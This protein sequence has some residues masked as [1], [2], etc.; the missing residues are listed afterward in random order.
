MPPSI[1][2]WNKFVQYSPQRRWLIAEAALR[3]LIARLLLSCLPFRRLAAMFSRTVIE[4]PLQKNER[5]RLQEEVVWAIEKAAAHLPGK[6]VCFPRAIAAQSMLYRRGISTTM[7][8]G[9][10]S[11]PEGGLIAHVWLQDGST[12][13][14]G[15]PEPYTFCVLARFPDAV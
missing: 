7:Y 15:M 5:E 12:G 9:A 2:L 4:A 14:I 11:K 8:Y 10:A 6:T 3:L 13:V 1:N